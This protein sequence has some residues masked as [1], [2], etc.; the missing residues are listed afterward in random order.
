MPQVVIPGQISKSFASVRIEI[1]KSVKCRTSQVVFSLVARDRHGKLCL[2]Q[3]KVEPPV[4]IRH[5]L[6]S[7]RI[8]VADEYKDGLSD[9]DEDLCPVECVRE[10]TT[11]EEFS[12]ILEKSKGTGSLVVVDFF[13]TSCGSCKYIEQGFAKL[14][15]KSGDHEAPVIFLKHNVMDEY[16]EQSEVADRLR[17]RAVPLFH[18]YKDG[19]LLE[20]F[21]TRDKERIVA[22]ILKY[23]SL[24]AEDI[25]G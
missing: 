23:S 16:D 5:T 6:F 10:F 4:K 7:S 8:R 15:K 1:E 14:C 18:F 25:L 24:E 17:I 11:D 22:A 19:V 9:E 2:G 20:A 13:R 12:K 3:T 21:P